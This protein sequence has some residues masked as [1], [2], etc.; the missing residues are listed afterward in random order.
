MVGSFDTWDGFVVYA[1]W[2]YLPML[3]EL[4]NGEELEKEKEHLIGFLADDLETL[5][6][7]KKIA[8]VLAEIKE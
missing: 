7:D 3:N 8:D 2:H 4:R 6:E 5:V 1:K